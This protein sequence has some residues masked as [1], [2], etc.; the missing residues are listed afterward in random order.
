MNEAE[1]PAFPRP[2]LNA[3]IA[4]ADPEAVPARRLP[5]EPTGRRAVVGTVQS[6][7]AMARASERAWPDVDLS[8]IAFTRHGHAV[9][10]DRI[11]AREASHP[12]PLLT[13]EVRDTVNRTSCVQV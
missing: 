12:L 3:A 10:T 4:A 5:D 6:A 11:A 8:G 9:P 2:T 7:A 1:A 13:L